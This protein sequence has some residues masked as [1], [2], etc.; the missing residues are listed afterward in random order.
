M[1]KFEE[2]ELNDDE[3]DLA[4]FFILIWKKKLFIG[5]LSLFF[6]VLSL[7]YALMLP[8]IYISTATLMPKDEKS[9]I[10]GMLNQYSSV[11]SLAGISLPSESS[12][13]SQEAISRVKSY[14]FFSLHFLPNIALENLMA[15]ENWDH[16][17]DTIYYDKKDFDV[18]NSK[19]IRKVS[20]PKKI[21]PSSQEA[22]KKYQRI[23]SIREDNKTSQVILSVEHVSPKISKKWTDLIIY[24]IDKSMRDQDREETLRS[25]EFLNKLFPTINYEEIK[26]ALSSLQEEQIKKLMMI[27]ASKDYVFMVLDSPIAPEVK[28]RPQRLMIIFLGILIGLVVSIIYILISRNLRAAENE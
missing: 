16:S 4:N 26:K 18:I 1:N 27:E 21:K 28:S 5:L 10:S 11:A 3:I 22:F 24:Q 12:S 6:G 2:F 19:W 25:I 17:T 20:Y 9:G 15:E 13:R 23:V 8:N 7:I 14:E